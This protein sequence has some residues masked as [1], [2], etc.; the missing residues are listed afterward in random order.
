MLIKLAHI[1]FSILAKE[2]NIPFFI[3]APLSTIDFDME[4]GEEIPIEQ[5]DAEEV[6][7]FWRKANSTF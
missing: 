5:R 2:H 3:A 7:Y 4:T 6:R 1:V